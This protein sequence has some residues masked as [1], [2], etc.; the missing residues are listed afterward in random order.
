[1]HW[2]C[3]LLLLK[4][5]LNQW[6]AKDIAKGCA[7]RTWKFDIP[8]LNIFKINIYI[9]HYPKMVQWQV[10]CSA[11]CACLFHP[12]PLILKRVWLFILDTYFDVLSIYVYQFIP[13]FLWI[14]EIIFVMYHFN[15]F[16]MLLIFTMCFN[17]IFLE[18]LM[19]CFLKKMNNTD[20]VNSYSMAIAKECPSVCS[21]II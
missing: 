9:L 2:K 19:K 17:N 18:L 1:M 8:F 4:S 12:P 16:K 7:K 13:V 11:E 20:F 14:L 6:R 10:N 3:L 21:R 15:F 5:F